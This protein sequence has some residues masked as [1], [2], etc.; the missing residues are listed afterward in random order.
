MLL[1]LLVLPSKLDEYRLG[2]H[3]NPPDHWP[4]PPREDRVPWDIVPGHS[5]GQ[6]GAEFPSEVQMG[7]TLCLFP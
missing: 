6:T 3:S 4:A 7:L 1:S 5:D 2:K